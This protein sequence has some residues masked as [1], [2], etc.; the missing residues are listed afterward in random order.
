MTDDVG[1]GRGDAGWLLETEQLERRERRAPLSRAEIVAAALRIVD[2][3]GLEALTMRRL[4]DELGVRAM[5]MYRHVRDKNQLLDLLIEG[6][7]RD[8]ELPAFTGDWRADIAGIAWA[9]R[10]AVI[11]HR[12]TITLLASRPWVGAA[13]LAGVD[14]T[15]GVFRKAGLADQAAVHAQFALGNYVTGFC[16]WEAANMGASSEDPHARAEA[17]GRY[18]AFVA[19]LPPERF[20]NL[21]AV[22]DVL[23]AGS[24]DERFEV[25]LG[26]LLDGIEA[27]LPRGHRPVSTGAGDA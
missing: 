27:T 25:G 23:V 2:A 21:V 24:L 9:M 11:R 10:R 3:D 6:V 13:G 18:R 7:L 15:I 20:P 4:G 1:A 22:A 12:H 8:V 26:F 14:E 5:A 19:S 17:L 16:A